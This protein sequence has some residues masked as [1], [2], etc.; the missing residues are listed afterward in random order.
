[1]YEFGGA[2]SL[3][4]KKSGVQAR[5]KKRH[6]P[7]PVLHCYCHKLQLACIQAAASGIERVYVT[8]TTMRKL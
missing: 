6:S 7:H 4:G 5:K 1:M 8:L 2:A 3:S